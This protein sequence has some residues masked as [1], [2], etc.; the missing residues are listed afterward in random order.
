[1]KKNTDNS[2]ILDTLDFGLGANA[3]SHNEATGLIPSA[4]ENEY[5][6]ESYKS[7]V[8]YEQKPKA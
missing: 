2:E 7:I 5:E 4:P 1:M 3:V 6:T 8:E